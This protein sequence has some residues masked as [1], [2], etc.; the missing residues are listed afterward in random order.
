MSIQSV[1]KDYF[2]GVDMGTGSVGWALAYMDYSVV[3]YK[4]KLLWGSHLFDTAQTAVEARL[5]RSTRRRYARSAERVKLL[6]EL[7][8]EE[9][10]RVDFG[11]FQRMEESRLWQDDKTENQ[12]NTLFNDV[13]YDDG[14]YHSEYKTIYH[15][16]KALIDGGKSF[17]VRLVYLALHH[18]IKHR[19]HFLFGDRVLGDVRNFDTA[20]KAVSSVVYEVLGAELKVDDISKVGEV[21]KNRRDGLTKREDALKALFGVQKGDKRMQELIKLMVGSTADLKKLFM[22]EELENKSVKLSDN[23][24]EDVLL[25]VSEELDEDYY[26]VVDAVKMMYDWGTL[27]NILSGH[28]YI[29]EGKIEAY[30]KHKSDLERLKRVVK[31]YFSADYNKI[32]RTENEAA[33]YCSYTG[34][35]KLPLKNGKKCTQADFCVFLKKLLV[36]NAACETDEDYLYIVEEL[37]KGT[38]MPKQTTSQNS[39]IPYQVN[40]MELCKILENA[41][42][43]LPFLAE[44]DENGL[45]VSDKIK[46]LFEF[47]IPYY[48]GPLNDTHQNKRVNGSCWIVKKQGKVYPWNFDAMVD[49]DESAERFISKMT[50]KCSYL[51]GE[52]VLPD[53]SVIYSK[54]KVLNEL[55]NLTINGERSPELKQELFNELFLKQKKVRLKDIESYLRGRGYEV[56][57]IAGISGEIKNNMSSYITFKEIIGDKA[58]NITMCE[59]II[60][61]ITLFGAEPKMLKRRIEKHYGD[62]LT[63]DEIKRLCRLKYKDWGRLSYKLLCGITDEKTGTCIINAMQELGLNLQEL[64]S[65]RY[66]YMS[67]IDELNNIGESVGIREEIELS[68]LSPAVKRIAIRTLDVTGEAVKLM[69]Y[70]PKKI[71]VEMARD[72]DGKNEKKTKPSRKDK[73]SELY[74]NIDDRVLAEEWKAKLDNETNDSLRRDKLFLY[75]SQLGKCMYSG[76]K[77]D[78][79]Q[80][81]NDNIYDIDHIYPQSVT[82]DDSLENRVL[83]RRELNE[84]KG[85]TYP[86][87]SDIRRKN[88]AHWKLLHDKKLI[89]DKKFARLTRDEE[90]TDEELAGFI[91]RQIVETRQSTKYVATLFK[92]LYPDSEVVY[93]KAGHVSDFRHDMDIVKVRDIND[94]HHAQDAYLN[95]VVGNVYNVKFTHDVLRYIKNNR[96]KRDYNLKK[97]FKYYTVTDRSTGEIVWKSGEGGT[98]ADVKKQLESFNI[99]CTRFAVTGKGKLFDVQPIPKHKCGEGV[100]IPL[101]ENDSRLSDVTRYGGY[102]KVKIAYFFCV[103]HT[104]KK[105]RIRTIEVM[106]IYLADRVGEDGLL[107]Y[108]IDS[109]GLIEPKIIVKK[110]KLYSLV[111]ING[112]FYYLSGKQNDRFLMYNA[113]QL[114]V[115]KQS[116]EYIKKLVKT[117][118]IL[119]EDKEYDVA[120]Q[121]INYD[122]NMAL[123][124]LFVEKQKSGIYSK[125]INNAL[126]I[127]ENGRVRFAELSLSNQC[128]QLVNLLGLF[129]GGACNGVNTEL[130]GGQSKG[131]K[132]TTSKVISNNIEFKLIYQSP[133][134]IYQ[135]VIDLLGES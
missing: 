58:D 115:D 65:S 11:F 38:F 31:R 70:P 68:A 17:D 41:E 73:L 124:D 133:T 43:Y 23:N 130:I 105:K 8:A 120:E 60:R 127:M 16:R 109:L 91:E 135:T 2:L 83:V 71:F 80:L 37:E 34:V 39:T 126:K 69:G 30:E 44:R 81:N 10:A 94:L 95:I 122:E 106:P 55:N 66:S 9:I 4:N 33:N 112:Y 76:E 62:V 102:N 108:C 19:G 121:K 74:K 12:K 28:N 97:L 45:T 123:Y 3:K 15:L 5:N 50:N 52:D 77:I 98:I 82:K 86:I 18:L 64:L 61:A 89:G 48:I 125:R 111:K 75:Y 13:G 25:N 51:L 101:K 29:C 128:I 134:G 72:V 87:S 132:I 117:R 6:Q 84:N 129:T 1:K 53:K 57:A 90:L 100:Q 114:C 40:K 118:K 7:F 96:G 131:N 119:S 99:Q 110:I 88:Y 92:R 32:F 93:V 63:A 22:L 46:K 35:S 56:N 27:E 36:K 59:D 78:F 85:D 24:V 26:A 103:E 54:F 47:R 42:E 116:S 20:F 104:E 14:I 113:V 107:D 21:I 67:Q 49:T 79:E